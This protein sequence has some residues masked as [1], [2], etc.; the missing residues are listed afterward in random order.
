MPEDLSGL[1]RRWV[2]LA[3]LKYVARRFPGVEFHQK[4]RR[5]VCHRQRRPSEA[6]SVA[7]ASALKVRTSVRRFC[8]RTFFP[9]PVMSIWRSIGIEVWF[10]I[11]DFRASGLLRLSAKHRGWPFWDR[12][13]RKTIWDLPVGDVHCVRDI[14]A[15]TCLCRPNT[16]DRSPRTLPTRRTRRLEQPVLTGHDVKVHLLSHP[17]GVSRVGGKLRLSSGVRFIVRKLCRII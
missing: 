5:I 3:S 13:T 14:F 10:A 7:F 16:V 17:N 4:G 8:W 12:H 6:Q 2:A 15:T 11:H 9:R 1:L